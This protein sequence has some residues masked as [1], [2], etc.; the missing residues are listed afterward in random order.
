MIILVQYGSWLM[1]DRTEIILVQYGSWLMS[2]RTTIISVQFGSW[3]I[4]Q[5]G[6]R[7]SLSS[8]V[9]DL[10]QT[11][12]R[13]FWSSMVVDLCQT[14]QSLT[15]DNC[16]THISVQYTAGIYISYL[17]SNIHF[18]LHEL[19]VMRFPSVPAESRD[20]FVLINTFHLWSPSISLGHLLLG[21]LH[22][23]ILRHFQW[24]LL[25]SP[26]IINHWWDHWQMCQAHLYKSLKVQQEFI[27]S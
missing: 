17:W 25:V 21:L 10:C 13:L 5:T 9:V 8:M 20:H 22:Q 16:I 18:D 11:G 14:G 3:L 7:L 15:L 6:P 26:G 4:C 12:P 23:V 24:P 27:K 19:L 2:D 1:S